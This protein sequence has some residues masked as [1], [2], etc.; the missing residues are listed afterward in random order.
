MPI[1]SEESVIAL[2]SIDVVFYKN[3][4]VRKAYSD[5]LDE[6]AKRPEF[7]PNIADKHLKLLEEISKC[8]G[9]KDIHW[10]DIKQV[11]YPKGYADKID[12][13][14]MLR[15]AQL[16]NAIETAN[17]NDNLENTPVDNQ[18]L[19]A[20]LLP[21]LIKHPESIPALIELGEKFGD[22]Q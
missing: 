5:F 2:N 9:L 1:Y 18:Q 20:Q 4:A 8:L 17:R 19:V 14:A 13:E 6:A 22:K 16:Q 15:K 21:E 11:Y 10:N 12:E 7:N 3:R